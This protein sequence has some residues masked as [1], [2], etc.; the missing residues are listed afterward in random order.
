MEVALKEDSYHGYEGLDEDTIQETR[1]M[2][3]L[4]HPYIVTFYGLWI[5]PQSN[6]LFMVMEYCRN[7]DLG[8][9]VSKHS[10]ISKLTKYTWAVQMTDALIY[11][12]DRTIIHRDLKPGNVLLDV[13]LVSK[14][15]DFGIAREVNESRDLTIQVGTVAFMP[16]EAMDVSDDEDDEEGQ[17]NSVTVDGKKWDVYSL[18][19]VFAYV[20]T[21]KEVYPGLT[22]PRIFRGVPKGKRPDVTGVDEGM[23]NLMKKMWTKRHSQRPTMEEVLVEVK[24]V[25]AQVCGVVNDDDSSSSDESL[26]SAGDVPAAHREVEVDIGEPMD[27]IDSP[28]DSDDPAEIGEVI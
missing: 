3:K 20:F 25:Q 21:G 5:S 9:Y 22:N 26:H 2:L 23:V 18:S 6:R 27:S 15:A 19:I 1:I 28:N 12:H 11:L 14:L 7:G 8:V 16:P 4:R 10:N 24:R 17:N 13:N